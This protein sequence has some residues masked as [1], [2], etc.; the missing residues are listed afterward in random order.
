MS[1]RKKQSSLGLVI[2]LIKTHLLRKLAVSL[3][4][5]CDCNPRKSTKDLY[6]FKFIEEFNVSQD[7]AFLE[8][9]MIK[10]AN[11]L[12]RIPYFDP[13]GEISIN[14]S[15][16]GVLNTQPANYFSIARRGTFFVTYIF[17][18]L[19]NL[20]LALDLVL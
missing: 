6:N 1:K 11:D 12:K 18:K 16:S 20:P 14:L 2:P 8:K 4:M 9:M 17:L 10:P 3:L 5:L 7:C 19:S 13:V 15:V